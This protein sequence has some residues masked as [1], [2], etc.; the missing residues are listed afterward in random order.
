MKKIQLALFLIVFSFLLS[1]HFKKEIEFTRY[2]PVYPVE[3]FPNCV[4]TEPGIIIPKEVK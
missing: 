4:M 1:C 3:I 2:E